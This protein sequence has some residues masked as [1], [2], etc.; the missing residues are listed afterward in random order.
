MI[1]LLVAAFGTSLLAGMRHATDPDHVVADTTIVAR[2][3]SLWRAAGVGA[4]WGLGHT[5][6]ILLVGA[7]LVGFKL[8]VSPRMGLSMEF[9][10]AAMLV[11]LGVLN[12]AGMRPAHTRGAGSRDRRTLPPFVVGTVHGLAG[13]AAATLFVTSLIP[14]PRWAMAVLVVFGAA[15][16]IGMMLVTLLLAIPS[17]FAAARV[18]RLARLQRGLRIASGVLSI[19]FGLWLAHEIGFR[20]GLFTSTPRWTAS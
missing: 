19:G 15:T 13:S 7:L 9:A 5:L 6:T 20:D 8:T 18:A 10:V 2:E 4:M 11:T 3:R 14:D 1:D 16:I 17:A 12:L